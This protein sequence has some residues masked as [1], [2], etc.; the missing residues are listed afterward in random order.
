MPSGYNRQI[1]IYAD[2]IF[3]ITIYLPK[4]QRHPN[5]LK[6]SCI[7]TSLSVNLDKAEVM[8]LNTTQ[9]S[10]RRSEPEYFLGEKKMAYIHSYTYVGVTFKDPQFPL[11]EAACARLSCGYATI[12]AL[13]RQCAHLQF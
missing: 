13:E 11:V 8:M 1:L 7:D 2:D 10:I 3:L 6:S 9:V 12:C 4:V 5:A